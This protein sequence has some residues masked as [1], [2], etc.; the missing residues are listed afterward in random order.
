LAALLGQVGVGELRWLNFVRVSLALRDEGVARLESLQLLR[1]LN[2]L[3]LGGVEEIRRTAVIRLGTIFQEPEPLCRQLHSWLADHPDEIVPITFD[4]LHRQVLQNFRL[5]STLEGITSAQDE[6]IGYLNAL[7]EYCSSLPYLALHDIR[8]RKTL[9]EIYVDLQAREPEKDHSSAQK[10]SPISARSERLSIAMMMKRAEFAPA[11]ILGGAGSG[12]STLLRYLAERAWHAPESIGLNRPHLPLLVPLSSLSNRTGV[13]I[14]RLRDVLAQELPLAQALPQTFFSAWPKRTGVPWLLL[15]DALDEVP[16][17]NRTQFIQWLNGVLRQLSSVRVILT[18]RASGHRHGEIDLRGIKYFEILPFEHAQVAT[19]S[20]KWFGTGASGFVSEYN[21][22]SLGDIEST[23]LLLTIAAKVYMER[24]NLPIR[25]SGLYSA[26]IDILLSEAIGKGLEAE[27]G[28][29]LCKIFKQALAHLALAMTEASDTLTQTGLVSEV[30]RY[31][32]MALRRSPHE[33]EVDAERFLSVMARRSGLLVTRAGSAVFIHPT[34][35][36]YLTAVAIVRE[37]EGD[38]NKLWFRYIHRWE[39]RDWREVA[40]FTFGLLS[41]AERDVTELIRRIRPRVLQDWKETDEFPFKEAE[42][43]N[44]ALCFLA[45]ALAEELVVASIENERVIESL[46]DFVQILSRRRI[47]EFFEEG[48]GSDAFDSLGLLRSSSLARKGLR[49]L[50]RDLDID[51]YPRFR[52]MQSLVRLCD[53]D[54]DTRL[55][56]EWAM[57]RGRSS[58][59]NYDYEETL[60]VQQD[61]LD[62]LVK[63]EKRAELKRVFD[64]I[65]RNE[66]ATS[67]ERWWSY[68]MLLQGGWSVPL[69]PSMAEDGFPEECFP[70]LQKI[71]RTRAAPL[72]VPILTR[73]MRSEYFAEWMRCDAA[74]LLVE[75]GKVDEAKAGLEEMLQDEDSWESTPLQDSYLRAFARKLLAKVRKSKVTAAN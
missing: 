71:A 56:G 46:L 25:R 13:F 64:F 68:L 49:A 48:G 28:D 53:D 50:T 8:P 69:P 3:F 44:E 30:A 61:A 19:F 41:D 35:Q 11:V 33:A 26:F 39:S 14:E 4:L 22:V 40:L 17:R 18:T 9:P 65:T 29:G 75:M 12:K 20:E 21:R 54:G 74:E 51:M 62:L 37:C 36:E 32:S 10:E 6:V 47:H 45:S 38:N 57:G 2:I 60:L 5:Q 1:R 27:L 73:L 7:G 24:G 15:L 34:F 23:P 66:D 42:E 70:E 43:C 58:S 63:L 72:V 59:S 31:I 55:I 52:A 16:S 67:E